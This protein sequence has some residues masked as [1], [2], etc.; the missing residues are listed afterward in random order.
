MLLRILTFHQ[1]MASCLDFI[2]VF[3]T[4][5]KPR[6]LRFSGFHEQTLLSSPPCAP[7]TPEL[8]R[9]GRHYQLCYNLKSVAVVTSEDAL[10]KSSWSIR[11]AAFHH[12]FDVAE[13]N[14]LWIVAKGDKELK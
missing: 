7:A 5:S 3:G 13:G 8:H 4:Q 1:V 11:Q 12:Q 6:D 14:A 10:V 9:S 2:S